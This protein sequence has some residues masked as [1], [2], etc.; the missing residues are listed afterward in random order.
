MSELGGIQI[1]RFSG[2]DTY[3]SSNFGGEWPTWTFDH[4]I[5]NAKFGINVYLYARAE[6]ITYQNDGDNFDTEARGYIVYEDGSKDRF[7]RTK[8]STDGY[9]N[10]R[11]ISH[12]TSTTISIDQISST[13]DTNKT[14]SHTMI[15]M[16]AR[17]RPTWDDTIEGK[18]DIE[19]RVVA[20]K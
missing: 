1:D 14:P 5:N 9:S 7:G 16:M 11:D 13:V 6:R 18:H 20:F 17:S 4:D 15:Q 2:S 3:N 8:A 12:S 19:W 10:D